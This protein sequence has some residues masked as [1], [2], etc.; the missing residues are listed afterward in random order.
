M[1]P[2]C[3]KVSELLS[4]A[5][6]RRLTVGEK[7]GLYLH[8]ALCEGC[9]R[10]RRQLEFIREAMKRYVESGETRAGQPDSPK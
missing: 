1:I 2:S 8:L 3:K 9:R 4:Q 10:F 5:Q 7:C 6:D